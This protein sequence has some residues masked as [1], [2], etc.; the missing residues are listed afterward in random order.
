MN[1][2]DRTRKISEL[3]HRRAKAEAR[4]E[5]GRIAR[6]DAIL[7]PLVAQQIAFESKTSKGLGRNLL[8]SC[9]DA[10]V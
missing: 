1:W 4:R 8:R 7:V 6:I 3:R 2:R 10:A 9:E 5:V